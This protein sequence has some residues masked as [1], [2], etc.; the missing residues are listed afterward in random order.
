[1]TASFDRLVSYLQLFHDGRT[2][3]WD[4]RHAL[5]T[6]RRPGR[7]GVA[8]ASRLL[9]FVPTGH[10]RSDLLTEC[11]KRPMNRHAAQLLLA[12]SWLQRGLD[13]T[14]AAGSRE[15]V[16]EWFARCDFTKVS[17]PWLLP[18]STQALPDK[19]T[20]YRGCNGV[21]HQEAA[22]GL[23]WSPSHRLASVYARR[24][25]EAEPVVV[26]A[27]ARR[28]DAVFFAA[29]VYPEMVLARVESWEPAAVLEVIS[30]AE[31]R[32]EAP[33]WEGMGHRLNPTAGEDLW[34]GW[35]GDDEVVRPPA[36]G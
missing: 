14:N 8:T 3:D 32:L 19:F 9:T 21:T 34:Q 18:L 25:G 23:A 22:A 36:C 2:T 6:L 10:C 15:T 5:A 11:F 17:F 26:R 29:A 33:V 30:D 35:Q 13:V 16:L 24:R 4:V 20:V 1:M 31:A 28:Q 12:C 27:E 7:D